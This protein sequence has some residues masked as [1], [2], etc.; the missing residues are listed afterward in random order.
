MSDRMTEH[1]PT[2]TSFKHG[3]RGRHKTHWSG[4]T[5]QWEREHLIPE[6]PPWMSTATYRALAVLRRELGAG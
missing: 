3:K 6:R 2:S 5:H 1:R 4:E